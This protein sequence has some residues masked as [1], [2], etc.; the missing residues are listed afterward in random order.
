MRQKKLLIPLP[1]II[2][3]AAVALGGIGFVGALNG[4]FGGGGSIPSDTMTRGLVGYW[5]MEEDMGTSVYDKSGN[6]NNGFFATTSGE[7]VVDGNC[8]SLAGWTVD[9][10]GHGSTVID[11]GTIKQT[12]SGSFSEY[13]WTYQTLSLIPGETYSYSFIGVS[14][15]VDGA[16]EASFRVGTAKGDGT[17]LLIN[18][19]LTGANTYSGTFTAGTINILTLGNA[20]AVNRVVQWNTITITGRGGAFPNR[21]SGKIGGAL[22]FD[23]TD[24]Y[25][26]T[27]LITTT[28]INTIEAWVKWD[29][30]IPPS[31]SDQATVAGVHDGGNNRLYIGVSNDFIY[32]GVGNNYHTESSTIPHGMATSTWNHMVITADGSSAKYYINGVEKDSFSYTPGTNTVKLAIGGMN[33]SS[34]LQNYLNG[35]IDEVKVYSRALSPAEVRYHYNRGGP[36]AHWKLDEGS[37]STAYDSTENNNDGT[38]YWMSTSTVGGWTAGK[39][40]S[41]LSFDGTDDYVASSRI[42]NLWQYGNTLSF[43]LKPNDGQPSAYQYIFGGRNSNARSYFYLNANGTMYA[44]ISSDDSNYIGL[45]TKSAVFLDG[46]TSWTHIVVAFNSTYSDGEIYINGQS[47][48]LTKSSAGT[49]NKAT[50][51]NSD[52]EIFHIGALIYNSAVQTNKFNG[53][54]DE[55]RIYNYTRTSDEISLDY[56]AGFAAYFGPQ[57]SCD[58]DPGSC[59][60]QGLVGYWDMEEGSGVTVKDKSGNSNNGAMSYMSTGTP[61]TTGVVFGSGGKKGGSALS[62][63]GVDDYVSVGRPSFTTSGGHTIEAWVKLSGLNSSQ[64]IVGYPIYE[65]EKNQ[66]MQLGINSS[67]QIVFAFRDDGSS[68]N[69]GTATDTLTSGVWYHI[70]GIRYKSSVFKIFINGVEK[71]STADAGTQEITTSAA[72]YNLDLGDWGYNHTSPLNGLIDE[73]HIY[74]RAL[75]ATEVRYH[76][77]RGG[78]VAHWKMD[79]GTGRTV[80]DS[81]ENNNDGT[82]VLGGSATSSAWATGQYGTA[83]SF[84]GVNDYIFKT[85]SGFESS[86]SQGTISA[87][88]KTNNRNEVDSIF[89]SSDTATAD[90]YLL[91]GMDTDGTILIQQ[92]NNDTI[93]QV[94]TVNTVNDNNWHHVVVVSNG[95]SYFLY[96]NGK[97]E[98]TRVGSGSNTGDWF[99]DTSGRDN[100]NIGALI[101]NT[102][103]NYFNGS[104]DDV[105]I[106]NYARTPSQ[107]QQDYNAGFAAH[108]GPKT[109]CDLDPG[110]CTTNG[111]V[112]YWDMEEG[113][114]ILIHDQS[115]NNNNGTTTNMVTPWTGGV[116]PGSGGKKGGGALYF[117]GTN[118]WVSVKQS[119]SLNAINEFTASFWI[120]HFGTL[121]DGGD[122]LGKGTS[123]DDRSILI[124]RS[125]TGSGTIFVNLYGNSAGQIGRREIP[126]SNQTSWNFLTVTYDGGSTGNS[127]KVY[128]NGVEQGGT[129]DDSGTFGTALRQNNAYFNIGGLYGS[130]SNLEGIMDEVRIYNRVLSVEEI[131]YHYNRGGPVAQWKMDEGEGNTVYDSTN[132]NNDGTLIL[133]GSA[134]SSAWVEGKYGSAL[135]FDGVNDYISVADSSSLDVTNTV[136]VEAWIKQ[137]AASSGITNVLRKGALESYALLFDDAGTNNLRFSIYSTTLARPATD[138][139]SVTLKE[140]THIVG[141]YDGNNLLLYKNGALVSSVSVGSYTLYDESTLILG[142]NDA[143]AGRYFNGFIDDVRIYNYARTSAQ[144]QQDYNASLSAHFK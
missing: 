13:M 115:G 105:R 114:G 25:V 128:I 107:I 72:A 32:W 2:I 88:I 104:I 132:N 85:T 75:S 36:V 78:P 76:Y 113:S 28:N 119:P 89:S 52:N 16:N 101:R 126:F 55:F 71:L 57:S 40:G 125:N 3:T 35:I 140:W 18:W 10:G 20:G 111:L 118:D 79:E 102:T 66:Y 27:N 8:D 91:F 120:K 86:D 123:S 139:I 136:T 6:A 99:S 14:E 23:G 74:S 138:Y 50:L 5:D 45:L 49:V 19:G 44:T 141:V 142:R 87:W 47:V 70:M 56:N 51:I 11:A 73:V 61:W 83:L 117:D 80:Y 46:P 134:T 106:Y 92:K 98:T 96:I 93:D 116:I 42:S 77:N 37:G 143:V 103:T 1:V 67:N 65:A 64:L 43:W 58:D 137:N 121:T 144:I 31:G 81:T 95:T 127:V 131:R 26:I 112:G 7:T 109:D 84:D 15:N 4:W 41:A 22:S 135:S 21:T 53:L 29:S 133:A 110:A 17:A 9:N 34:A 82:L 69:S 100:I 12:Q 90:Y 63:D 30:F 97:I 24:D 68:E 129:L 124:F 48:A 108:F 59:M 122:Y 94:L 130:S 39:Y 60:T 38:L 54:I 62:F 33:G